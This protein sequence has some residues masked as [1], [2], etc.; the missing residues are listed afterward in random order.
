MNKLTAYLKGAREEFAKV[1]WP[2]RETA[3]QHTL[4]VIVIS[5][6]VAIFLGAVDFI[7]TKALEIFLVT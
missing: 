4:I 1:V 5:L 2:S 6:A 7:L 3:I